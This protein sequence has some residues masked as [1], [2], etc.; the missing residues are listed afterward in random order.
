MTSFYF[1][2]LRSYLGENGTGNLNYISLKIPP[3][4]RFEFVVSMEPCI[5]ATVSWQLTILKIKLD[6][7]PNLTTTIAATLVIIGMS[8]WHDKWTNNIHVHLLKQYSLR[9]YQIIILIPINPFTFYIVHVTYANAMV[10][11][12]NEN[13]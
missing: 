11:C 6:N 8:I 5:E 7:F 3:P 1:P 12:G 9:S 13:T 2:L 4:K 10:T